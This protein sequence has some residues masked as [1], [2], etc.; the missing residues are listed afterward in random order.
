MNLTG[1]N[2]EQFIS[3]Y[4]NKDWNLKS[5]DDYVSVFDFLDNS[6]FEMQLGVY[7]AYYDSLNYT[8]Y[9]EKYIDNYTPFIRNTKLN[10]RYCDINIDHKTLNEAYKVAFKKADEIINNFLK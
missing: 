9:V 7:L 10:V 4:V 6:P 2:K 3:W 1:K 5:D 8:I